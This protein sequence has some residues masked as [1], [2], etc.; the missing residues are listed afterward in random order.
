M[1]KVGSKRRRTQAQ[2]KADKEEALLKEQ[3]TQQKLA[4]LAEAEQK[5]AHYDQM[6][7]QNEQAKAIIGELQ[8]SGDVEIDEHG[9]ITPSKR[10][11]GA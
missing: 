6:V 7:V 10:K 11:L 8:A 9:R 1:L 3:D 4:R 2:V 5:L